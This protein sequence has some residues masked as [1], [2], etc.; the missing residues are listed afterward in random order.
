MGD[1]FR[2]RFF[3]IF[4]I[5]ACVLTLITMGL[6]IAGYGNLVSDVVST[7][8]QP[9]QAFANIIRNSAS[10]FTDYFTRFNE[11]RDENAELRERVR[12]LEAE[13]DLARELIGQNEMLRSFFELKSE[14]PDFRMQEATV[15]ARSANNYMSS[16][17]INRGAFHGV[18]RDM[19]VIAEDGVV[20]FV[21]HVDFR[22]SRVSLFTH[23]SNN[24][25]AYIR[26]TGDT[27]IVQGDFVLERD[28]LSRIAYLSR[29]ADIQ[30]GDRIYSSGYGGI[31]PRGLFVG[32]ILE[33]YGDPLTQTPAA[34]IEP[35]V[36][37]NQLRDV[38]IILEFNWIFD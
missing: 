17:T 5:T 24:I 33:V 11:F 21:S 15:I 36:N 30:A 29:E 12:E 22:S 27:G 38:M 26:R 35:G 10:G 2:N 31:Y 1:V 25:G 13:I 4:L 16:L 20:G 18:E 19:P 34:Y 6:N 28:G 23:A 37:F 8:L 9:F 3:I 14:R 7:A 32:T